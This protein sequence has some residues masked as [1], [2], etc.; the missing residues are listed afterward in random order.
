MIIRIQPYCPPHCGPNLGLA[1]NA[2]MERLH[3][4]D[5]ALFVDHDALIVTPDWYRLFDDASQKVPD[6]GFITART[7]RV[8]SQ[9][10][11]EGVPQ[12]LQTSEDMGD[13]FSYGIECAKHYGAR[14]LP[15]GD[16]EFLSGVCFLVS[17]RT[18]REI[19]FREGL[20]G[21]D[22]AF[23]LDCLA[24][25]KS[26]FILPGVY[27]YHWY[28]GG[29]QAGRQLDVL[30]KYHNACLCEFDTEGTCPTCGYELYRHDPCCL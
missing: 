22:Y 9:W 20:A 25:K 24:A 21:V 19:R 10:Q 6:C 1:Y 16:E 29:L 5:W 14:M 26:C 4:N 18:W 30:Q 17:K 13:H 3:D 7:N 28:G 11:R 2:I 12:R 15:C 27:V 23:H 8:Y